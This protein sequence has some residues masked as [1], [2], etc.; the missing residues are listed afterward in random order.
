MFTR[1][2]Q[3]LRSHAVLPGALSLTADRVWLPQEG[4]GGFGGGEGGGLHT[5]CSRCNVK[6]REI[7][8]THPDN[9]RLCQAK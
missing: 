8:E 9:G 6:S 4:V 2:D 5:Q 1:E 7:G 3:S